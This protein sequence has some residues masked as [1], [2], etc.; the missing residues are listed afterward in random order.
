MDEFVI[1][2]LLRVPWSTGQ[3]LGG[4]YSTR[5]SAASLGMSES[6]EGGMAAANTLR[7]QIIEHIELFALAR[8][9][10][11]ALN[12]LTILQHSQSFRQWLLLEQ[13]GANVRNTGC[14]G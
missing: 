14:K 6:V 8:H 1:K 10:L 13:K 12:A 11:D 5:L 2:F 9:G 4:C 3:F 7:T